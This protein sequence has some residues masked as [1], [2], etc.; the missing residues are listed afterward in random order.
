MDERY[1]EGKRRLINTLGPPEH[2]ALLVLGVREN[3]GDSFFSN[4]R[5]YAW[6]RLTQSIGSTAWVTP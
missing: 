4:Q 6:R 5:A 2:S 1:L 3:V